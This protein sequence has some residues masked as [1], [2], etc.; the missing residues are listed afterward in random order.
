MGA[1]GAPEGR[2]ALAVN[3]GEMIHL[4]PG[5]ISSRT[6]FK[7]E[8]GQ[9]ILFCMAPGEELL[10][11]TA[12][13]PA[14]VHILEGSGTFEMEGGVHPA[15]PGALFHMPARLPHAVRA[16]PGGKG[17]VFLLTMFFEPK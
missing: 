15:A 1:K 17:L 6:V 8:R 10:E 4:I 14:A 13:H 2:R 16:E 7:D 12:A 5:G 9:A 3:L 11:H